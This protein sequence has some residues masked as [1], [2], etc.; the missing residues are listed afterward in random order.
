MIKKYADAKAE[1]AN[2][3]KEKLPTGGYVCKI[4]SAK[5]EETEWGDKLVIAFDIAEGDYKG[6]Y[7]REFDANTNEDKKW[8]GTYRLNIPA[9]DG[10]EK[11]GWAKKRFNGFIYALED[12]NSG[13]TFDWDEKKLKGK[14][15]GVVF[16]NR[17]WEYNGKTGWS[18]YAAYITDVSS[19]RDGKYRP[20]A[21][22]PLQNKA[23]ATSAFSTAAVVDDADLPF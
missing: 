14:L 2:S 23:T 22:K 18:S 19:V 15:I 4:L 6:F 3:V 17:E 1:N 13:Y 20:A 8:K 5:V 7:Q 10:S 21:D 11:D 16:G 12:G 9:D